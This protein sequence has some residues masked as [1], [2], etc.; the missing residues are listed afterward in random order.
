MSVMTV[1]KYC[2]LFQD[3]VTDIGDISL[4]NI[5][6]DCDKI[7]QFCQEKCQNSQKFYKRS[8]MAVTKECHLI[9]TNVTDISDN[10]FLT[11]FGSFL[12][13]SVKAV[14]IGLTTS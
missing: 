4:E 8:V 5:S 7:L 14:K 12:K 2:I 1:T 3:F 11:T 13:I 10:S 9:S 6:N